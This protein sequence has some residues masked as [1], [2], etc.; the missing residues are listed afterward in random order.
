MCRG[1]LGL[2]TQQT[3]ISCY[4]NELHHAD[5]SLLLNKNAASQ[6][7]FV[8]PSDA[9]WHIQNS[10]REFS[11]NTSCFPNCSVALS[12]SLLVHNIVMN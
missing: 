7:G 9:A 2:A 6:F 8:Q 11:D 3:A 4:Y 12:M 10:V 5:F 1:A